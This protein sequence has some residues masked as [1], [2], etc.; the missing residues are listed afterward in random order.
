MVTKCAE[1]PY[2]SGM[3]A[4]LAVGLVLVVGACETP[5][6]PNSLPD[7]AEWLSPIPAE[8]VDW[9]TEVEACSGLR[10]DLTV[11]RWVDY[12]DRFTIPNVEPAAGGRTNYDLH[13]VELA[14]RAIHSAPYVRHEMLHMLGVTDHSPEYFVDRCGDLVKH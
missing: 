10:G 9:W 2:R 3:K 4:M 12:P 8:Y 1:I 6:P 5:T 7:G 13:I 14:G 11:W